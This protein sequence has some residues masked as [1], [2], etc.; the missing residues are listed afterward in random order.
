MNRE[1]KFRA[2]DN[3]EKEMIDYVVD[4]TMWRNG[5]YMIS[6]PGKERK[7]VVL[8]QY[9]GLK[10]KNGQDIYEGDIVICH[11]ENKYGRREIKLDLYNGFNHGDGGNFE[12]IGN[13][14]QNPKLIKI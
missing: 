10:D 4:L 2:W 8:M 11:P 13:I 3:V 6:E 7:D 5:C 12:I 9:T 1:I 14:Y